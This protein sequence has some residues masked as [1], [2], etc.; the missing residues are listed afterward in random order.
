M[1]HYLIVKPWSPDFDSST[2]TINSIT[3]VIGEESVGQSSRY[4]ILS[5]VIEEESVQEVI[6][7]DSF[8]NYN[9]NNVI[10]MPHQ[11]APSRT[12]LPKSHNLGPDATIHENH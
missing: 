3:R 2:D 1:R 5:N 12:H 8:T 7:K 6:P 4:G 10:P 11:R 9:T